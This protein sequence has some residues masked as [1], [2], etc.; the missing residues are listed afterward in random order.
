VEHATEQHEAHAQPGDGRTAI[1]TIGDHDRG[2][3]D[4]GERTAHPHERESAG[5][6]LRGE[7]PGRVKDRRDKNENKGERRHGRF[8]R[9]IIDTRRLAPSQQAGAAGRDCKWCGDE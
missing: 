2:P 4:E 3:D 1:E 7:I 9:G 5:D 6:P 8:M